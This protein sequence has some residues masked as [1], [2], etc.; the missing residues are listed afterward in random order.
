MKI[1]PAIDLRGG[2]CVR[3]FHGDYSQE[4]IYGNNPGEQAVK[5]AQ[6]GAELI[7]VVDLD[8]AKA[9]HIVNIDS[10]AAICKS[11]SVPCEL[12][13]GIRTIEDAEMAFQAG[14]C[15]VILGTVACKNPALAGEFVQK[16][17]PERVV[18]GIDAKN[19]KVAVQG[20]TET[21]GTD[22]LTLAKSL[23]GL[24]I[25]HIIYTDIATDGA[26][27]GP[28][29]KAIR[30]LAEELPDCGIVASGGISSAEDISVLRKLE[31][32]NL[33]GVIVGKALYDG[34]VTFSDLL[35]AADGRM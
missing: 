30:T 35:I 20:W 7:H 3:L 4:T 27:C 24:G 2:N 32:S 19:G 9:G 14:I 23:F 17:G 34:R 26:L 6:A 11:T 13:G 16:F 18:V 12:G 22:S 25:R 31:L 1:I 33:E 10:I 29:W 15:R 28:N 21:S 5:W 8:G